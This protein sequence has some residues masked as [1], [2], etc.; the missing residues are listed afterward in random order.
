[1]TNKHHHSRSKAFRRW[2]TPL[3]QETRD[4]REET[5]TLT[6]QATRNE[7][8]EEHHKETRISKLETRISSLQFP[9][10]NLLLSA[11]CLL[12]FAFCFLPSVHAQDSLWSSSTTP[13]TTAVSDGNPWELGVK[14][15]S[16]TAGYITGIR[17]YKGAGNTGTHVGHLWTSSGQMLASVTFT[18]ET[19]S[20]WQQANFA[21]PVAITANTVYVASYWD[22]NG[23]Y[24]LNTGYFTSAYSNAPLTA[25]VNN[26]ADGSN[27]VYI[28]GSSSFPTEGND[29]SNFW[30]D[31]VFSTTATS[32]TTASATTASAISLFSASTTPATTDYADNNPYELGVTFTSDVSGEV[33]GIRFY[34]GTGNTGT[35][36]GHLWSSTGTLL[37]SATFTNETASGWQQVSFSQPVAITA[38]TVYTASYWDPNGNYALSRPYFTTEYNNAPLHA[39]ADGTSGPNGAYNAG[40]SA[41]PTSD[42]ESSNYWVDVVFVPNP[43]SLSL[44]SASAT[45]A[46]AD[47]ADSNPYELGVRFTSDV[48]GTV[49]GIRFYKGTGNTGTHV[50]HLWTN[51]GTLLASA[52]FTNETASGWQQV[53]FS[54]PVAISANTVYVASY[55]DPNG[56]YAITRP[57]FT[58]EYNNAPLHALA[59]GTS[60]ANGAYNAGSSG[61]PT[62]DYE[63][64]NYWVDVVFTPSSS[65]TTTTSSGSSVTIS[66]VSPASGP[67][68]GGT[69]VT[70][71]GSG[72]ASG[73]SVSFGGA[74]A[75][76]VNFIS[77]TQL[78]AVTPAG[79]AGSVSVTVTN[80]DP[81]TASLAS[82]FDYVAN[83][84][85]TGVSPSS[86]PAS[87]GT[88]VTISGTGFQ[89]GA[90]VAFGAMLAAS[91][92]VNS[93]T[94]IQ[95]V[96]PAGS[97]GTVSITV[98]NPDNG[99]GILAS[100]FT[101]DSV[102]GAQP[103]ITSAT[104]D[105]GAAGSSASCV[106]QLPV[107][108][109]AMCTLTITGSNFQSGATVTL[110]AAGAATN[111]NVVT[112]TTITATVPTYSTPQTYVNITVTNPGGLSSTLN[113][114]FFYGQIL[115][116]DDFSSGNF[117]KWS[118]SHN[119]GAGYCVTNSSGTC[120]GS[121]AT[122]IS[123]CPGAQV[124][125]GSYAA[126]Q[127]YTLPPNITG[128][129]DNDVY[130]DADI[131]PVT[132]FFMR[133]FVYYPTPVAFG[134]AGA[135]SVGRKLFYV[136][137]GATPGQPLC[138]LGWGPGSETG[139][140]SSIDCGNVSGDPLT[141]IYYGS[142]TFTQNQWYEFEMEVQ[143][144]TYS[145]SAPT[146]DGWVNVWSNGS[147]EISKSAM[148]VCGA[149]GNPGYGCSQ[150]FST[151]TFGEQIDT[152]NGTNSSG[153]Q[154]YRYFSFPVIADAYIP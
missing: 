150:G 114:G 89:S 152:D 15:T 2:Y 88:T 46:T 96:T 81:G 20:G 112:S 38:N 104:T 54:Q 102:G 29:A 80:S 90:I 86:G 53:N 111:V 154:E 40:S 63:S 31:V 93:P 69:L 84:T 11:F 28:Y 4:E 3:I 60:G 71:N 55:W 37:A 148:D 117:S 52:T 135:T 136:N 106:N 49:T 153:W 16:S 39:L 147:L 44:F 42:Y 143:L 116:Q 141:E 95:A 124:Y 34:K 113:N 36:I 82:G 58:T 123:S 68:S 10:S 103:Q 66:S 120:Q 6:T 128:N 142:T 19:A 139:A 137:P 23:H 99:A 5:R 21:Q 97:T 43:S 130:M 67:V 47:N 127:Y 119:G 132:H 138:V 107:G 122:T 129:N 145:S 59:D 45:P 75:S 115:F 149:D 48:A 33:T 131:S 56:N 25:P 50:G 76:S 98:T 133:T 85:V 109:T 140:N 126:C 51:T 92:T 146:Y 22:P 18:N 91:V 9:V 30:V 144:N 41:F 78:T 8:P 27:G 74:N 110:G 87:G 83:P 125:S 64:T 17:F 35:H 101:F 100:A 77:S 105:P 73:A 7:A 94:Q 79:S 26:G 61:F 12:L 14:F 151:F 121:S 134:T 118:M 65:T 70:I 24:S 72:F 62:S 32:T 13:A 57:Y 108:S 1:M